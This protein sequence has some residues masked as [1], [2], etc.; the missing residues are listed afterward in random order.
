M[1]SGSLTIGGTN[2]NYGGGN[3]WSTNTAGLLLECLNNTEIAVHDHGQRL[4]SLMY[5]E[6]D[7]NNRIT[8]GRNM[9]WDAISN[10]NLN[11]KVNVN[12]GI[13][14]VNAADGTSG[15]TKGI[16][17]RSGYDTPNNNIYNCS[18]LAYDHDGQGFSDGLS[19]N[20]FDG[21][22]FCTGSNTRSEKMRITN[23]GNVSISGSIF[24]G[25]NFSCPAR[26]RGSQY[27]CTYGDTISYNYNWNST[28]QQGWFIGLNDFW[29]GNNGN[30]GCAYLTI[31]IYLANTSQFCCFCRVLVNAGGGAG[32]III[33]S[34]NPTSGVY[35]FFLSNVWDSGGNNALRVRT[36][37]PGVIVENL[38]C[39][40]YG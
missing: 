25:N 33:D 29:S 40:I 18:I 22:S 3:N 23:E 10:L 35:E 1:Q 27:I 24:C 30:G 17:F 36:S 4:A 12:N 34:K 20:G 6:G 15:G 16:I 5:Y 13:L 31:A 38:R 39:K 2:A 9:G 26:I 8:I 32:T 7:G 14:T 11:G 21:I 28:G 37:T 19:I